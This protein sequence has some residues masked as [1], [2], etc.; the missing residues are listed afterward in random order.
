[1]KLK[2]INQ[3]EQHVEKILLGAAVAIAGGIVAWQ[4]ISAPT[5]KVGG[6]TVSPGEVD[7]MLTARANSLR[8]NMEAAP[9]LLEDIKTDPVAPEFEKSL[10][11]DVAPAKALA[12]TS[13]NFNG[14]LVKAASGSSAETWYLVPTIP[15]V[16]M[17]AVSE[18]PDALTAES[19]QL[20]KDASAVIAARPDFEKIDGPRDIVWTTPSA[21][22]D[23]KALRAALAASDPS[24]N[25]PK[26]AVPGVWFQETPYIVDLVFE[27]REKRPDGT[28]SDPVTVPVFADRSQDLQFRSRLSN[29]PIELRDEVFALLGN[30]GNQREILQP[31]FY[32]TVND[33][34]VSP[35][36]Q[37]D[38]EPEAEATDTAAADLGAARRRLQLRTELVRKKRQAD[39]IRAEVDKLGGMWD[40]DLEKK[41]EKEEKDRKRDED[42]SSGSG[43]GGGA[44]GGGGGG[45]GGAMGGKNNQDDANAA[46]DEKKRQQER[47][48]K[49]MLL[50]RLLGEIATMEKELGVEPSAPAAAAAKAPT[51]AA[52]DELVV[53]GHDMEVLPGHVYQYRCTVRVYNPFFGKGNQLVR[54]QDATGISAA[55]TLDSVASAWSAETVVSPKVR[56]FASR[57]AIGE[58]GQPGS[59]SAQFEVFVLRG[60]KWRRDE[61]SVRPGDRIGRVESIGAEEIDFT[62]DFFLLDLVEDLDVKRTGGTGGR[63]AIPVVASV[64]GGSMEIRVP[65]GDQKSPD[66]MRLLMMF[67]A[68]KEQDGGSGG[69]GGDAPSGGGAPAGGGPGPG[70][71]GA[72]G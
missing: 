32:D 13:P 61:V 60:G 24:A 53:W 35:E 8:S 19:A 9:S 50:K 28:W 55:F 49:S 27:R 16:Q 57:A 43:G 15:A 34:F 11:G 4:F 25:P 22:I 29:P 45:L 65:V 52:L 72:G 64:D 48:S 7:D 47:K 3:F 2:G 5:A 21:K 54:D 56:F 38:S 40:D 42:R 67:E 26:A 33:A 51:L 20:A 31:S 36:V 69:K 46:R 44:S 14:R 71:P 63:M 68:A 58:G 41:R 39:T 18:T 30:E 10:R 66:R 62:T 12:R 70:G 59:G 17:L 1:M 6:K 23:L 37:G